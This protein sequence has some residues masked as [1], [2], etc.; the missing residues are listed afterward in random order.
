MWGDLYLPQAIHIETSITQVHVNKLGIILNV[1]NKL[2][3]QQLGVGI[4]KECCAG[5]V[6]C[7][8]SES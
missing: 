4:Q 5:D 7:S 3:L 1:L 6:A 2:Q 8:L